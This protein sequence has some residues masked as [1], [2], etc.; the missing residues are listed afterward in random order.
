MRRRN[1]GWT[2]P[3]PSSWRPRPRPSSSARS[4]GRAWTLRHSPRAIRG[5]TLHDFTSTLAC[6]VAKLLRACAPRRR[7]RS[8]P[9]HVRERLRAPHVAA[10]RNACCTA[11]TR[12]VSAG[13]AAKHAEALMLAEKCGGAHALDLAS[14]A[15]VA[16]RWRT[17]LDLL[18]EVCLF[19]CLFALNTHTFG[20]YGGERMGAADGGK[21]G[22][23]HPRH[24]PSSLNGRTP[25][26]GG[27]R[28]VASW[29]AE[30]AG[31]R[32]RSRSW[33]S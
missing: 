1:C 31:G 5:P 8:C 30:L 27:P 2:R 4:G 24:P 33:R 28:P 17:A 12:N 25:G 9:S 23:A 21:R 10:H 18:T 20:A 16:Q 7:V 6:M 22:R 15:G 29:R 14:L 3:R 13:A 32:R 19:V 26:R 11:L